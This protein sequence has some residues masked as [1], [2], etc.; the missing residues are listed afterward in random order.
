MNQNKLIFIFHDWTITLLKSLRPTIVH[1]Y[2]SIQEP[3][4]KGWGDEKDLKPLA[5]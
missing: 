4:N 3:V 1:S 2:Y 5:I